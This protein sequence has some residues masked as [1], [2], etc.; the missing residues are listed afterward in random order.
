MVNYS[1]GKIYKIVDN[2]NNN[3][4]IGSTCEPTLARR[5]ASHRTNY[6]NYLKE[7]NNFTTSFDIIK[8]NNYEIILIENYPCANKDELHSRERFHIESNVCINKVIPKRTRKE[9]NQ[10]KKDEIHDY[11]VKYYN[12]IK[13]K[14][15]YKEKK[16][17][18]KKLYYLKNKE[19]INAVCNQEMLC[20]CGITFTKGNKSRHYNSKR[21]ARLMEELNNININVQIESHI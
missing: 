1:L 21:H 8:N 15:D 9:Y 17:A 10:D 11:N 3:I 19:E 2:T 16:S 18:Y 5:L 14:N 7:K 20:E 13:D 4:Y 6:N 12:E